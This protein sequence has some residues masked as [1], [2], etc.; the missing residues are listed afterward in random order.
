MLY[1]ADEKMYHGTT[2]LEKLKV[3]KYSK[4][5]WRGDNLFLFG[6]F[7]IKSSRILEDKHIY[8]MILFEV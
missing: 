6:L 5:S 7:Y 4:K 3:K 1:N 8:L 2:R